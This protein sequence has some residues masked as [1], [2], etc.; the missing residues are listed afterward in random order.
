[1]A[2]QKTPRLGL[3]TYTAGSDPHPGRAAHNTERTLLDGITAIALKGTT[4]ARPA[5]GIANRF[6]WDETVERLYIDN[7]TAWKE[8]TTN[9]GGG[10]GL[11]VVI[12]GSG[13]EGVSTRSARADHTHNIPLATAAVNGAMPATDKSK[14]DNAASLPT[15]SRLV[16]R[17]AN[18]RAQVLSPSASND[19]A[20]KTYVDTGLSTKAA[21]THTHAGTDVALATTTVQ[22]AMSGPDKAK[23][24][25]AASAAT[26]STLVVRDASGRAQFAEPSAAADVASKSYVD[27]GL[28]TKSATG[29]THAAADTTTGV[30]NAARLPAVTTATQGAMLAADKVK[31]NAASPAAT[32]NTIVMLDAAGRAQVASP[33]A[34]AD[35]AR[36][37]YVDN[38]LATKAATVHTHAYDDITG[39]PVTFA[40]SAHTHDFT[41]DITGKPA[42]YP[43]T[44][45]TVSGKPATFAPSAH[46]HAWADL[47][48][49]P[50]TFTPSAHTHSAADVNSG[51]LAAA[52][53]PAATTAAQG[54][55][56]AADKAKL[57]DATYMNTPSVIMARNLSGDTNVNQLVIN[58]AA[59]LSAAQ[60]TRKDYVDSGLAGKS[61]TGHTHSYASI[62]GKPS[63]F[64][65][66]A[67][68]H[69]WADLATG[70]PAQFPP[71]AHGHSAADITSGT[72]SAF[73][74]PAA[75]STTQ[76]AMTATDKN[77][78]DDATAALGVN[79]LVRRDSAN[80]FNAARPVNPDNVATKDYVDDGVNSRVATSTFNARIVAGAGYTHLRSPD[81]GTVF[82]VNDSGTIGSGTIY[83]T[84]AASAGAYRAVWVGSN[85]VL[86]YNLSSRKFKQDER[87]YTV[88]LALLRTVSPKWFRYIEDVE[89]LG[90][91]APE[92]VN[93]IAED[94][95]DAGLQ[96]YV[97]YDGEGTG[98]ENA[99]T[100][101]EQLM[102]NALWSICQQQQDAI[103]EL[104][105]SVNAG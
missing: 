92:R 2:I 96:E 27:T 67:H 72:I 55:M 99:Q 9:G 81:G 31:L 37:D 66:S 14:L 102:V 48:D 97:S 60:A 43:T 78:L 17:D 26:A 89:N 25:G 20:N 15:A 54:A 85:G 39:K 64:T 24:D 36:K 93:F 71:E 23:L 88:P 90:D 30:F 34:A 8:I 6:Y 42:A 100:I 75:N 84:N 47:T 50:A 80:R 40:P 19:I 52:R 10:A 7:G 4:A 73:R 65:P 58:A 44:W 86:G 3:D 32:P 77:K 29:H 83:N 18:G 33:S 103:E 1:M 82:A 98:R 22:G 62:T 46:T 69:D 53:L 16:I 105:R 68:T 70:V 101:N 94:L 79:T 51:V 91:A 5:A 104:Q 49:P 35:I 38:G 41:D 95:H 59:P 61:D 87:P 11:N 13:A 28:S 57:D 45:G 74:L 12:G 76:G 56:S 21:S 63:T